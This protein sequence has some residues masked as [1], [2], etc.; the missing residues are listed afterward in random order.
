[1]ATT[2]NSTQYKAIKEYFNDGP[3]LVHKSMD[4]LKIIESKYVKPAS[5]TK[6]RDYSDGL[7]PDDEYLPYCYFSITDSA[8]VYHLMP[9]TIIFKP[10]FL[11]GRDFYMNQH[12]LV[13][14]NEGFNCSLVYL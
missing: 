1:M 10:D 8:L 3:Y 2:F 14:P 4:F 12:W 6:N 5:E 11:V 7:I 9:V 13:N